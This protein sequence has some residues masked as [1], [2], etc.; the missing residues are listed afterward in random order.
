MSKSPTLPSTRSL[1]A[2]DAAARLGSFSGA[3]RELSVTQGAV[4]HQISELEKLLDCELFDRQGRAVALNANGSAYLPYA[5]EALQTLRLGA[6][7]VQRS[8][9]TNSSLTVTVSP[10]FAGK[11]LVPRLGDFLEAHPDI[12]LRISASMRHIDFAVDDVDVAVRHGTGDWPELHVVRL[13]DEWMYPVISPMLLG[14]KRLKS[15]AD[16]TSFTLLHDQDRNKWPD[17]LTEFGVTLDKD[18]VDGPVFDQTAYAIDAAVAGQGVALARSQL[19]SLELAAGRLVAPVAE[20]TAAPFS[21]WIVCPSGRRA[22]SRAGQL[23]AQR[24]LVFYL[25]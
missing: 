25:G 18:I 24:S 19:V 11:W 9:A 21:Y 6:K 2:F 8:D 22:R 20:K 7:S 15:L 13:S 3:A 17:W 16:L 14:N 1:R 23:G 5:R 4:S 10:N 12:D